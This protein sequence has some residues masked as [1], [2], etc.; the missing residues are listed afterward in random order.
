MFLNYN[1]LQVGVTFFLNANKQVECFG[2]VVQP[3]RSKDELLL[4]RRVVSNNQYESLYQFYESEETWQVLG[5]LRSFVNYRHQLRV[6]L[7]LDRILQQSAKKVDVRLQGK[8]R[9]RFLELQVD[10]L[11]PLPAKALAIDYAESEKTAS[12]TLFTVAKL[13]DITQLEDIYFETGF[14]LLSI[15]LAP[16][17]LERLANIYFAHQA[18]KPE[19]E[20]IPPG[21]YILLGCDSSAIF[22][23]TAGNLPFEYGVIDPSK[24]LLAQIPAHLIHYK[25]AYLSFADLA[26]DLRYDFHSYIDEKRDIAINK[27]NKNEIHNDE[28]E[29][30]DFKCELC[31][32]DCHSD[33]YT[34][35]EQTFV[36]EE[37]TMTFFSLQDYGSI[38]SWQPINAESIET[39]TLCDLRFFNPL[40]QEANQHQDSFTQHA[41]L[42]VALAA[43]ELKHV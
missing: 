16:T 18:A 26:V 42:A 20:F 31:E 38:P 23:S 22:W 13:D 11:F 30:I 2:A 1:A 29:L 17:A 43:G 5:Q 8:N 41:L 15:E 35:D 36:A 10:K 14:N 39:F 33:G 32:G 4:I 9:D 24:P 40:L 28:P 25:I 6:S 3:K 7:P 27:T 19:A 34:F 21:D 37:I 12:K